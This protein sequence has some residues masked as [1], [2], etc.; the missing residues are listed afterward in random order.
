MR[1]T[2]KLL[3][4][5]ALGVASTDALAG[6]GVTVN[7]GPIYVRQYYPRYYRPYS[8]IYTD[9]LPL[10]PPT[11]TVFQP[12]PVPIQ[13]PGTIVTPQGLGFQQFTFPGANVGFAAVAPAFNVPAAGAAE[14]DVA[15]QLL[16]SP[17]ERDRMEA[18]I[19][20]GRNKVDKALDPLQRVLASDSSARVREAAARGL[21][22]FGSPAA[23]KALQTAAQADDDRDVRHSAQFA[24]ESIRANQK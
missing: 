21:G 6:P 12:G 15:L 9:G 23:L 19:A 18:A 20:L 11:P 4:V 14:I 13:A 17:R 2:R 5:V 10:V 16:A 1:M 8:G 3:L 22:L 7:V 24:A